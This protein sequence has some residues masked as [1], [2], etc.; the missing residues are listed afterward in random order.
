MGLTFKENCPDLRNTRVIELIEEFKSSNCNVDVY[1]PWVTNQEAKDKYDV[2][3]I[4]IPEEGKYDAVILVVAHDVFKKMGVD[5]IK[6][7]GRKNH[8][9]FDIKYIFSKDE[10]D[11]RL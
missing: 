4:N 10:V 11:G 6:K 1:D 5:K 9:L 8:V 3:L 2:S 7:F